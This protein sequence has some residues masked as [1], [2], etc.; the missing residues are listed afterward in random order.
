MPDERNGVYDRLE[1]DGRV[2]GQRIVKPHRKPR[3]GELARVVARVKEHLATHGQKPSDLARALG[4]SPRVVREILDGTFA[5]HPGL[6]ETVLTDLDTWLARCERAESVEANDVGS[7]VETR[8]AMAIIDMWRYC[9]KRN[10]LAAFTIPSGCGKSMTLA[11]IRAD[12]PGAILLTIRRQMAKPSGM[13][14]GVARAIGVSERGSLDL[15]QDRV[16]ECLKA[17]KRPLLVDESHKLTTESLDVLREV[18]DEARVPMLLAA[19][20]SFQAKVK[21]VGGRSAEARDLFD[22]F[23]SRVG[24]FRDLSQLADPRSGAPE[25]L[26]AVADVRKVFERGRV[27]LSGDAAMFLARLANTAGA[28]GLRSCRGLIE[29]VTDFWPGE[30]VTAHLLHQ[31]LALQIGPVEAGFVVETLDASAPAT[32]AAG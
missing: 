22:Q 4:E 25:P 10:L 32:A 7:F 30:N 5:G 14:R 24:L 15:L 16:I 26:F 13:L 2:D 1:R 12:S 23:Y 9:E 3:G 20:P 31:A 28:G 8:V 17:T 27:R 11:A 6:R 29:K 18:W 19:T 21:A